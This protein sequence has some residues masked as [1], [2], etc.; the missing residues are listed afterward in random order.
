MMEKGPCMFLPG[1]PGDLSLDPRGAHLSQDKASSLW[2]L[3]TH[4]AEVATESGPCRASEGGW[5]RS[6]LS[7]E[8]MQGREA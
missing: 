5:P 2:L 3:H 6:S 4:D 8:G 1:D 7:S